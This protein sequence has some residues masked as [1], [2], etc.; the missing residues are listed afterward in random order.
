MMKNK[1]FS[2]LQALLLALTLACGTVAALMFR[3]TNEIT[4]Q[5]D[6]AFVDCRVWETLSTDQASKT[7]ITVE[8]TG[9]ISAYIRIRLVTY[10]AKKDES[11]NL[12]IVG[13]SPAP[14][15]SVQETDYWF[16]GDTNTF[17]CKTA[18]EPNKQTP[19]LLK[20]PIIL[21]EE[22]G[23][24]QVVEVFADA[25]QSLPAEAVKEA[26]KVSVDDKGDL[27]CP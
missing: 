11:N 22:N 4:N 24:F 3:Q 23:Y 10:W 7:G 5:F 20:E 19:D 25:I 13:R 15:L 18:I 17:Y 16:Q 14:V 6:A 21:A 27:N 2:I 26:W 1:R 9:N 8:N 12:C